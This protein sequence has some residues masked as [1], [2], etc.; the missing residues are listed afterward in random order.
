[1]ALSKTSFRAQR[2]A[3]SVE[4]RLRKGTLRRIDANLSAYGGLCNSIFHPDP[5]VFLLT[6]L[7]DTRQHGSRMANDFCAQG[8]QLLRA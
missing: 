2:E 4:S 5:S 8:Q 6:T 7:F 1:M 3:R